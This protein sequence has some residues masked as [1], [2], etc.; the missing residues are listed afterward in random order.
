MS[1]TFE[2]YKA[3][4]GEGKLSFSA[5]LFTFI[6]VN[7]VSG[8]LFLPGGFKSGGWLF[9]LIAVFVISIIIMYTNISLSDCTEPAHSYS[10]SKIGNKA[11]GSFGKYLVEYLIAISQVIHICNNRFAFHVVMLI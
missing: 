2:E 6:K 8:F 9:S 10:F 4:T 11:M 1:T 7:M 5:A 3:K